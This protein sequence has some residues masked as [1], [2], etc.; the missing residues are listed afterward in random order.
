MTNLTN[1]NKTQFSFNDG[2]RI[3]ALLCDQLEPGN[4]KFEFLKSF[5]IEPGMSD[6]L[7][8]FIS[9]LKD[10]MIKVKAPH[11]AIDVCGTGGDLRWH[12]QYFNSCIHNYCQ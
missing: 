9:N 11:G 6:L 7:L 1:Y 8:G 3:M 5:K 10:N 12:F 2:K 4:N